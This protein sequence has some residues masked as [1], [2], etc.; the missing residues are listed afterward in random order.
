MSEVL[1]S[2]GDLV[3]AGQILARLESGTLELKYKQAEANVEALRS[4]AA[5]RLGKT[6]SPGG[7]GKFCCRQR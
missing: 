6:G 4:P 5:L 3:E 2:L 7:R 1:V